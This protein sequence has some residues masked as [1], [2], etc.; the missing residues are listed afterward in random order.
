MKKLILVLATVIMM[1]GLVSCDGDEPGTGK[2][3]KSN[4][5][6]SLTI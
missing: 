1:V 3:S 5:D 4:K 2:T 6:I